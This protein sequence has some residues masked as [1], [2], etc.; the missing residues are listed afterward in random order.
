MLQ[1]SPITMRSITMLEGMEV[2]ATRRVIR[3]CKEVAAH[4][5]ESRL[6][7]IVFAFIII[8]EALASKLL[9]NSNDLMSLRSKRIVFLSPA[10]IGTVS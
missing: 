4:C 5:S 10:L 6:L 2:R 9:A 8:P 3:D 1:L 7:K